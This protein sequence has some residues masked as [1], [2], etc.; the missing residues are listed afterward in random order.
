MVQSIDR[1]F[2]VLA[3]VAKGRSGVTEIAEAVGLP[4]S[5]VARMLASLEELGAL[6]RDGT[7]YRVGDTIR[8]LAASVSTTQA[9]V[10]LANPVLTDLV[11]SLGEAAG[12]GLP[13]GNRVH[14]VAQVDAANP[15][16]VRDWTG[17]RSARHTTSS[18]LVLLAS[19]PDDAVDAY[20]EG[21]L[22]RPTPATPVEPTRLRE[23]LAE[24]R[25]LGYAWTVDTY[26]EGIGSV[27][28]PIRDQRGKVL[29]AV[30]AHGPSYRFPGSGREAVIAAQVVRAAERIAG[31]LAGS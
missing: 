10:R 24:T 17:E 21:P 8:S 22:E 14:Y 23:L 3:E 5:T 25:R 18:G 30:H 13:D 16:Q 6:V 27:A 20:L 2:R 4:K 1:A 9:L 29:A 12:L 26:A 11:R 28:A 7:G 31:R 15:V 19:W